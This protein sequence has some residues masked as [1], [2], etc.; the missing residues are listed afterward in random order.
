MKT[1]RT[2]K[3]V[4]GEA[5]AASNTSPRRFMATFAL[6]AVVVGLVALVAINHV[7]QPQKPRYVLIANVNFSASTDIYSGPVSSDPTLGCSGGAT[8]LYPGSP[9]CLRYKV[10]NP[11][12]TT[13][14]V[15]SLSVSSV[16]FSPATT[17]TSL[18]ACK[19]SD[20]HTTPFAPVSQSGYLQV[21]SG[22]TAYLG[23]PITLADDGNQ[24]NCK[25]GSFNFTISGAAQYTANTQVVLVATPSPATWGQAVTLIATVSAATPVQSAPSRTP[26]GT[27]TFYECT[28]AACTTNL[29]LGSGALNSSGVATISY[30]F[31]PSSATTYNLYAVYTP[32]SGS[33]D[34][35]G[36]QSS[37]VPLSVGFT[38]T[39]SSSRG[40]GLT[41]KSGQTVYITSTGKVTGGVT[42][43]S[44]GGLVVS[45][46]TI[47]GG[48]NATAPVGIS[49]C[50]A[51]VS[52]GATIS[53][54]T[55]P[56]II[57][58]GSSCAG[59]S[60]PGGLTVNSNTGGVLIIGNNVTGGMTVN[61][62][63]G[64]TPSSVQTVQANTISG[65]LACASNVASLSNGG[66]PNSVSGSRSG[67]CAGTF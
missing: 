50:G 37:Q 49:L 34:W 36:S 20:F 39:V 66:F 25:N 11:L 31:Y 28:N 23:E 32:P 43:Q 44:G 18:P 45:G 30:R 16:T 1:T 51:V 15:T 56:V 41:V 58:Y 24:D 38:S 46:G 67:Q 17:N 62:N 52:G 29:K 4:I 61:S 3:R 48:L 13:I 8:V 64:P 7:S 22:G 54:S 33:T 60:F 65:G 9:R 21:P 10:T 12:N 63:S 6:V 57:G 53:G 55:G 42:V 5:Q 59:N 27:G 26:Y 40:G 14:W 19:A 35:A 2:D 47:S